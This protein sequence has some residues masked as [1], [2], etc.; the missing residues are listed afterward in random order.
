MKKVIVIGSGGHAKVVI[1][2]L[3]EM[4]GIEIIGV[5]SK[6]L[7]KN[8][9]FC[10]YPVLGDDNS[11]KD[12]D[13]NVYY[14]AMGLGG[15]SDNKLRESVFDYVKSLGM[16]FINVIHPTAIISRKSVLGEGIVIFP[17][18]ILNTDTV[19]G[20]N[21]IIATRSSV[22]HE[23]VIG[24]HVLVSAGVTIGAYSVINNGS[25]LALGSKVISGIVIGKNSLIAA[26]AVVV[27]N[28][29]DNS[30]VFGVPAK[31]KP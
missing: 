15:Y 23:T 18:V 14:C 1:D 9:T 21:T 31:Q 8:T 30:R 4:S 20:N 26:G 10:N 17:G 12:Y 28:V 3:E 13:R 16:F 27:K 2:I 5:T 29:P 7:D 25:L 22:D 6:S 24:D 19:I 11:L